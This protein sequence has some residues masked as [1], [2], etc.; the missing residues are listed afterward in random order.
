MPP[1]TSI[2]IRS[3][4]AI[5]SGDLVVDMGTYTFSMSD[6]AGGSAQQMHGRY[7]I[8]I[9]RMDDGSWKIVRQVENPIGTPP[10]LAHGS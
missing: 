4:G 2:D 9:Q 3:I 1:G 5:G 6:S 8:V 7:L 10:E